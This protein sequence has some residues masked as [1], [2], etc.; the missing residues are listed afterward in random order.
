MRTLSWTTRV[1]FHFE[2]AP[3]TSAQRS[4]GVAM[5]RGSRSNTRARVASS[6]MLEGMSGA[7]STSVLPKLGRKGGVTTS[8]SPGARLPGLL[9]LLR[10]KLIGWVLLVRERRWAPPVRVRATACD[11]RN[12][13]RRRR[14][15]IQL[16][17]YDIT[18]AS[19]GF[20]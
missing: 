3:M 16:N 10:I 20:E 12:V 7:G 9:L 19:N 11:S 4:G 6:I 18:N 17:I 14:F 5:V 13:R 1:P 2:P 8:A 15:G